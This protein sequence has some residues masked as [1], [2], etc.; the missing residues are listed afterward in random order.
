MICLDSSFVIKLLIDEEDSDNANVLWLSWAGVEAIVAPLLLSYEVTSVLRTATYRGR[1]SESTAMA[2][3]DQFF[4]LPIRFHHSHLIH[5]EALRLSSSL[6]LGAA[7]DSHYIALASLLGCALWTAD[8][9]MQAAA[10]KVRIDVNR[11]GA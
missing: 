4:G 5:K 9:G 10:A 7:Y 3:L 6:G 2:G 1:I 8:A 11:L